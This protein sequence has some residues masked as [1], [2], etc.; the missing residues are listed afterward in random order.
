MTTSRGTILDPTLVKDLITKVKGKSSL[1]VLSKQVPIPFNG[2]KEFTFSLDNEIDIVAEN[3]AK[4]HGGATLAPITIVPIKF[5]Y[6]ARVSDEFMYGT[7]EVK[8]DILSSFNDGFSKKVAKGLDI[9][10]FHGLNPRTSTASAVVGTNHFDSKVTQKVTYAAASID[11]NI[12][13]AISAIEGSE[14]DITGIALSP[15]ARKALSDLKNSANERLYPEL[16]WGGNPGTI[17]GLPVNVNKT[18]SVGNKDEAIVGDFENMFKWG[19][20]KQIPL[21]IIKYGDPD[22]SGKDLKGY[23]QVYI[24]SEIYIGWGILDAN[25][26]ARIEVAPTQ[27]EESGDSH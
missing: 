22:N 3:G 13:D 20:S 14:R 10:A 1:A 18:V 11:S 24:R 23:N 4:S 19:Y 8:L 7:E 15:A 2:L 17:N 5:E 12:E 27:T 16:A 9:A 21:E 6:G 25:S 26:F